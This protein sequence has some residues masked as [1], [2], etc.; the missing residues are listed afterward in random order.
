MTPINSEAEQTTMTENILVTFGAK[1]KAERKANGLERRDAA[2]QLRLNERLIIMM[3]EGEYDQAI[4]LMFMRGYLRAYTKLLHLPEET[5]TPILE[6]LK[7]QQV[8]LQQPQPVAA[9]LPAGAVTS[10]NYYMQL[11]TSLVILTLATLV[12]TWWYSHSNTSENNSAMNVSTLSHQAINLPLPNNEAAMLALPADQHAA[13]N[14]L[15]NPSITTP[16]TA[17]IGVDV[18]NT[19]TEAMLDNK[20]NKS[21]L[22]NHLN[23]EDNTSQPQGETAKKLLGTNT[24]NNKPSIEDDFDEVE[25]ND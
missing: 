8:V 12:G 17:G 15:P 10:S 11:F 23:G 24:V 4:P 19:K 5:A 7:P 22:N 25:Y 2:A 18:V 1:L 3:E 13:V 14:A 6:A 21:Q 16:A 20:L 9:T